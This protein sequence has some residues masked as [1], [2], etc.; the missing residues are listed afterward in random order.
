MKNLDDSVSDD[1]LR[2]HF[3]KF[4]TILSLKLMRDEKGIKKGFGF[5]S[6]S[7]AAEANKAKRS[8]HGIF[9]L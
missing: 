4:G 8:L 5:V 9:F 3:S 2:E 1:E 7:S 6:F